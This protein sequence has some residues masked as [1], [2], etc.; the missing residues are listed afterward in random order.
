MPASAFVLEAGSRQRNGAISL[1]PSDCHHRTTG[2]QTEHSW[3]GTAAAMPASAF[4]PEAG[5]RQ[6]N[7][8]PG[9]CC[10]AAPALPRAPTGA[11]PTW[12]PAGPAGSVR[13][14]LA[15]APRQ[16][17]ARWLWQWAIL[18]LAST[19]EQQ[20]QHRQPGGIGAGRRLPS[21]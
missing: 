9:N 20:P 15:R 19:R 6:R 17:R 8:G 12:R 21:A 16:L 11:A 2:L 10:C 1:S 14:V 5:S 3:R 4:V 18:R 7:G 13:A